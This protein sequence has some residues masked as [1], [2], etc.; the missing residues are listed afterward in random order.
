M[1]LSSSLQYTYTANK[2]ELEATATIVWNRNHHVDTL[3][4][5]LYKCEIL[6]SHREHADCSLCITRSAK[7]HCNWCN[8]G[9]SYKELCPTSSSSECPKPRID[10]VSINSRSLYCTPWKQYC[11]FQMEDLKFGWIPLRK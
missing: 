8:D 2:G 9:C 3:N 11:D 1:Y 4:V 10:V 7:Y 6:G 5:T